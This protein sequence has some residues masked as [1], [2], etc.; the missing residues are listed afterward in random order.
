MIVRCIETFFLP[1]PKGMDR[2]SEVFHWIRRGSDPELHKKITKIEFTYSD[3]FDVSFLV[4]MDWTDEYLIDMVCSVKADYN[5][6]FMTS[7]E[8]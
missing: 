8:E 1:Q 5:E 4:P 3:G 6:K 7:L 2:Q